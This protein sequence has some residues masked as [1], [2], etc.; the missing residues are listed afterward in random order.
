MKEE[1]RNVI[2][3]AIVETNENS[4]SLDQSEM[5][6]SI[7]I[8]KYLWAKEQVQKQREIEDKIL[9]QMKQEER[10][11]QG[12]DEDM[13]ANIAHTRDG[14]L[15]REQIHS[16][17]ERHVY[18]L[19]DLS[20]DKLEGMREY[21]NAYYRGFALSMFLMSIV[22]TGC[23]GFLYGMS[24]Q[25]CLMMAVMTATESA[26]L[27]QNERGP[28]IWRVASK[29]LNSLLFPAILI[30]FI[31]YENQILFYDLIIEY[32]IYI[33]AVIL[34]ISA[35]AYFSYNPYKIAKRRVKDARNTLRV[36]EKQAEKQVRKNQK[37]R[38]KSEIR[39]AKI[40]FKIEK[41]EA[42]KV[43]RREFV[44]AQKLKIK[45]ALERLIAK[46]KRD[47]KTLEAV[48][49]TELLEE[50]ENIEIFEEV[51]NSDTHIATE[52]KQAEVAVGNISESVG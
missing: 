50:K 41:K 28:R 18:E 20:H 46:F 25:I 14:R 33:V 19:H 31:T 6:E 10:I 16:R 11:L 51:I 5:Q 8:Q 7:Q 43:R 36:L 4:I 9:E 23:A 12:I 21:K 44:D 45:K 35:I 38:E 49:N 29:I 47:K 2:S 24:S 15:Y 48:D 40:Q 39:E 30:L 32:G 26:L 22:L 3:D 34:L 17:V 1:N 27:V 37:S 13:N 42:R 52:I